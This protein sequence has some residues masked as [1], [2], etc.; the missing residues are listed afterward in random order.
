MTVLLRHTPTRAREWRSG[1]PLLSGAPDPFRAIGIAPRWL[2]VL[3]LFAAGALA[4]EGTTPR[5]AP[6]DPAPGAP[7]SYVESVDAFGVPMFGMLEDGTWVPWM[8]PGGYGFGPPGG[9]AVPLAGAAIFRPYVTIPLPGGA[10]AVAIGDVTGDGRADVVAADASAD[11]VYVL[12]QS[13]SGTLAVDGAYAATIANSGTFSGSLAIA[14]MNSDGRK[15]VLVSMQDAVGVMLQK[16]D[17]KLAAPVVKSTVH[18]SF[19]NV[20]K[21]AAGDFDHDGLTDVAT[22][23]WGTQSQAMDVFLREP[24]GFL[25]APRVYAAPHGGYDDMESGDVNGD[26]LD[27]LVVMSGQSYSVDNFCVLTQNTLGTLN[28]AAP[29]DLGFNQNAGGIGVGDVNGDGRKDVV[30]AYGGNKPGSNLALFLQGPH[31]L[32]Q[33]PAMLPSYDIPGAVVVTDIDLDGRSD[34]LVLHNGWLALGVYLQNATGSLQ[35]EQRF[36]I[37]YA[38]W[39]NTHGLAVGDLNSDGKPDV[40]L[41]S[42]NSGIEVLYN[43][44]AIATVIARAGPDTTVEC[45]GAATPVALDGRRSEGTGLAF[46]WSAPDVTFDDSTSATPTGSFPR[47]A[48]TV[49]LRVTAGA[50]SA[51]DTVLVTVQDSAPPSL[52]LAVEPV[53]LW[54]PD[55]QLVPVSVRA[56]AADGCDEVPRVRL[57][58][59]QCGDDGGDCGDD[60]AD[61]S[62][63]GEFEVLLRRTRHGTGTGRT[64]TL[65]FEAEDDAGHAT[66]ASIHVLVPRSLGRA[67]LGGQGTQLTIFGGPGSRVTDVEPATIVVG[68]GS[69]DLWRVARADA[70]ESDVDHDGW[71]DRTWDLESVDRSMP[72]PSGAALYARWRAGATGLWMTSLGGA[73]ADVVAATSGFFVRAK[74]QPARDRVTLTFALPG[75]GRARLRVYDLSGRLLATPVDG[76]LPAG[77]HE[78]VF[79]PDRVLPSQMLFYRLEWK[80]R[81]T[82]GRMM[83][84]R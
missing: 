31:G 11:V 29:Y 49:V 41:G 82:S 56:T 61:P 38:S 66:Q 69:A 74:D 8:N 6:E 23:D 14:D 32:L 84:L 50:A 51:R 62:F 39:Y 48:T 19:S 59:V 53:M 30:L 17:G 1:P 15:D 9:G 52:Q 64:Y 36:P 27:D 81:S 43:D 57:L 10:G 78:A 42:Y 28:G 65:T 21:L 73:T 26:G 58:S 80:D 46:R 54:P 44:L 16:P 70:L 60:F 40:A 55:H 20:F 7:S 13:P 63:G 22:I 77:H 24:G 83:L 12:A 72:L 33:S 25:K 79:D 4:A 2:P 3:A 67:A 75:A 68:S 18:S 37:G 71:A 35:P 5:R 34:V 47:G 76:M 45:A